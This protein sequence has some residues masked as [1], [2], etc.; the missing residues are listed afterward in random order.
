MDANYIDIPSV[1]EE[2]WDYAR[3]RQV[4]LISSAGEWSSSAF[5]S[6]FELNGT[7]YLGPNRDY[8]HQGL[9]LSLGSDIYK[10]LDS[11]LFADAGTKG[12]GVRLSPANALYR[13]GG[14]EAC[15]ALSGRGLRVELNKPDV[16]VLPLLDMREMNQ[17]SRPELHS[18]QIRDDWLFVNNGKITV[19]M[20]PVGSAERADYISDWVYKHGSGFRYKDEKGYIRFV[21]ETKQV[22]APAA[23]KVKGTVFNIESDQAAAGDAEAALWRDEGWI[24][25][26]AVYEPTLATPMLLR[27]H[28]LRNF[29]LNIDGRWF[30]EAGCWWFRRPWVRDALEGIIHN[31]RVYGLFGWTERVK[32]IAAMLL[33]ELEDRRGL[34]T[35]LGGSEFCADA[36]PLLIYLCSLLHDQQLTAKAASVATALLNDMG[37]RE[38]GEKGKGEAEGRRGGVPGEP[39]LRGGL[40]AC[41]PFQSWTDARLGPEKRPARLPQGWSLTSEEW[42]QPRYYLPEVNGYWIKALKSLSMAA[43]SM[44]VALQETLLETM[45]LM[46]SSFK[47]VLWDRNGCY[48]FN[49]V[50]AESGKRDASRTSMGIVGI[51]SALH[52]FSMDEIRAA[53]ASAR[54]LLVNR[55]LRS[56]GDSSLLFGML[57][58]GKGSPF[59]GDEEYHRSVIWP[60]D[61]PYVIRIM[62][63]LGMEEDIRG[64]LLNALDQAMSEGAIMYSS[65][66]F[67]LPTGRNPNPSDTCMN[68]IPLKNPAQYW[69]HWCDPF[70][71]RVFRII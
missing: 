4:L 5:S 23:L 31:F 32:S 24:K 25:R 46:E 60:R 63:A 16:R 71:G 28:A 58:T 37:C 69:S 59:L 53:Y 64:I 65:E 27:I 12:D 33:K 52:L 40:V 43:D 38:L 70:I 30:P 7:F 49:V 42:L 51:A 3:N 21:R 36:P 48:A 41:T 47:K 15:F 10:I 54:R 26:I 44:G 56:L 61:T 50:D 9:L 35:I 66:I 14:L 6:G 11:I 8:S 57:I 19:K 62:E 22:Y 45:L 2:D 20:G 17:G 55:R 34:P 29:G 18:W 68:I 39:V 67:G 1:E 13:Y